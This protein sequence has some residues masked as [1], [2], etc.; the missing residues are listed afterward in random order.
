MAAN[1]Q[2]KRIEKNTAT[3][4]AANPGRRLAKRVRKCA[5]ESTRACLTCSH[6]NTSNT[7]KG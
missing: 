7:K 1:T 2:A 5:V 6:I 3:I 4:S